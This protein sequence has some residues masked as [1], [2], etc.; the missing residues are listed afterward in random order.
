MFS[1]DDTALLIARSF[2]YFLHPDI[3]LFGTY[4]IGFPLSVSR[5]YFEQRE[6]QAELL[7]LK[8]IE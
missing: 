6:M 5:S 7:W 4:M 3:D 8:L 2:E 1:A